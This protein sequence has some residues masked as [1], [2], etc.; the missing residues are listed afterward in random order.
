MRVSVKTKQAEPNVVSHVPNPRNA[1]RGEGSVFLSG[2]LVL[3]LST[4]LVKLIGMLYKIPMLHYLGSEGMGYFNAAYEW[5][6]TLCVI[7][8]SGLPLASSMF[9]ARARAV[10][11]PE[12]VRRV[13]RLSLWVFAG[14]GGIGALA[15][16]LGAGHLATLIG[17]P[18][19][20]YALM[21]TAPTMLF[22]CLSGAYRGYF[23]G[24]K[25]MVP[26]A[27]SQ[28]IEALGKLILGL[29]FAFVA[30]QR[31]LDAP[32]VAAWAMVGLGIGV[33]VSTLYLMWWRAKYLPSEALHAE[34][35]EQGFDAREI[36]LRRLL[37]I[38]IPVT[39]S[40]S[41]VSVTRLFDMALILRRLQ[42]IGYD[43]AGANA[44]YGCYTTMAIPLFNLIPSLITSVALALVPSLT[45]AVKTGD[46]ATQ[47]STAR[48][49]IRMT[50]LLSLPASLAISIYSKTI[51]TLL[52]RGEEQNVALAAP[53]LS[54]LAI[55]IFFS[56]S[57]TTTNAILQ[58]YGRVKAPICSM[59]A[60]SAFKLVAAYLLIG[61]PSVN[62]Y[63]APISTFLCDALIVGINLY[64][65]A[66]H[67]DVLG[68]LKEALLRP[69]IVAVLAVGMPGAVFALLTRA[70][71]PS[72]PL[73]LSAVPV[74]VALYAL[75]CLGGGLI[76]E[77]EM[78]LLP[79]GIAQ[80][81]SRFCRLPQ[82]TE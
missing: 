56:G 32:R 46:V 13:E 60:G 10:G 33:A 28:V 68:S 17:S 78:A 42:H 44:L 3:T 48:T 34:Q 8:T 15:L 45:A 74:T 52:F 25:D 24:H 35:N 76:G 39:L 6:A 77:Q 66:R 38:A 1:G 2:V 63:G 19:T 72:L 75:L 57:I 61:L 20:R 41:V 47:V 55:S 27:I 70:G 29:S 11:C 21:A 53:M 26:T 31:G 81:F 7:A 9:I 40:S 4:V 16:W 58:A 23:Q 54:I 5:Y 49:S 51:L 64:L 43:T 69:M 67:T 62:I 59:L 14:L 30:R 65:I 80:K 82:K 36:T 37:S 79:S 50:A 12:A 22:S 71:Y 18:A 73:F